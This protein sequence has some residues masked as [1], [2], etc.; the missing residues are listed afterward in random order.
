MQ[1][2]ERPRVAVLLRGYKIDD[3]LIDLYTHLG[4]AGGDYDV[5]LLVDDTRGRP[6]TTVAN[7]IWFSLAALPEIGLQSSREDLFWLCGDLP[8]FFAM[9]ALPGYTHFIQLDYDVH[10]TRSGVRFL[11]RVVA[12]IGRHRRLDAIGLQHSVLTP[13]CDWPYYASAA[14][15]FETVRFFFGPFWALSRAA[16]VHLQAQ[17][18]IE[19]ARLAGSEDWVIAEAS[20]PSHLAAAGFRCVDL[21]ELLPGSYES[22]DHT[23][24][25]RMGPLGLP[26]GGAIRCRASIEMVHPVYAVEDHLAKSV[27][28]ADG[29]E[30]LAALQAR[31]LGDEYGFVVPELRGRYVALIDDLL[32]RRAA[33]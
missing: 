8:M 23:T 5:F 27:R 32:G 6:A 20:I 28:H 25:M 29:A 7:V 26:L 1:E 31:L 10:F 2:R 3:K 21:A 15:M 17:R 4:G 18:Q 30:A 33:A 24:S 14:R 16:L 9:R 11:N 19:H 12:A 13:P 22:H